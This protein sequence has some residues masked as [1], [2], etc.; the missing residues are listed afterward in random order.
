MYSKTLF[1][2]LRGERFRKLFPLIGSLGGHP[3]GCRTCA[4]SSK[5]FN[6]R[7]LDLSRCVQLMLKPLFLTSCLVILDVPTSDGPFPRMPYYGPCWTLHLREVEKERYRL[8]GIFKNNLGSPWMRI[9]RNLLCQLREVGCA[10][11]FNS[12]TPAY[13]QCQHSKDVTSSF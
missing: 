3:L 13:C 7:L 11:F 6:S 12:S 9:I 8:L 4:W 5:L 2:T 10:S 1:L